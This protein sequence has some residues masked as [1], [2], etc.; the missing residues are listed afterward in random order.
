[1]S[2]GRFLHCAHLGRLALVCPSTAQRLS[3]AA[4]LVIN[5]GGDR[6][7]CFEGGLGG[8]PLQQ[9]NSL[10]L[11]GHLAINKRTSDRLKINDVRLSLLDKKFKSIE[12]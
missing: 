2:T 5:D 6:T 7:W 3:E 8:L 9:A 10:L 12:A 1:M 4:L 11:I